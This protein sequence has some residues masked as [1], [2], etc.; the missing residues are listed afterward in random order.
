[1]FEPKTKKKYSKIIKINLQHK[2][3]R[4]NF[5]SFY[6]TS[7]IFLSVLFPFVTSSQCQDE[8]PD[9]HHHHRLSAIKSS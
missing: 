7:I 9:H 1:M 5:K 3:K 8:F 6:H 2:T 4:F